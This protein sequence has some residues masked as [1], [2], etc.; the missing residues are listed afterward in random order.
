LAS[1]KVLRLLQAAPHARELPLELLRS[2][3]I[4]IAQLRANRVEDRVSDTTLERCHLIG[5][6]IKRLH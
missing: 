2:V 1:Q 3:S 4:V 5:E 6:V